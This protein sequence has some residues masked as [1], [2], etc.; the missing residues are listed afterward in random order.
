MTISLVFDTETTGAKS[1]LDPR[2]PDIA[3]IVQIFGSLYEHDDQDGLIKEYDITV[4]GEH[5]TRFE[6]LPKP[7]ATLQTIVDVGRVIEPGAQKVHGISRDTSKRLGVDPKNMAHVFE[8]FLDIADVIVAHNKKFDIGILGRALHEAG[9][10]ASIL[11]EKRA[12]CTMNA[13]RP[14]M[15]MT[16]KVYGDFKNPK[17]I[18]AYRYI[19][20]EDFKGEA[21][22]AAADAKACA[23]IYFACLFMQVPDNSVLAWP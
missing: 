16:P 4:N 15:R 9:L 2:D 14:V 10:D 5:A 19:F 23:D 11:S 13:M 21:H 7:F 17:L 22:D 3:G 18:E 8:D 20:N 12:Y 6:V 1:G